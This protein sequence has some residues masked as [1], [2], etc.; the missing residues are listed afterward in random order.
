M[1]T[2]D[3]GFEWRV[4]DAGY[5]LDKRKPGDLRDGKSVR[6]GE[7]II[8][9]GGNMVPKKPMELRPQLFMDF[10]LLDGRIES[11]LGFANKWGYLG[12]GPTFNEEDWRNRDDQQ[13]FGGEDLIQWQNFIRLMHETVE[14][15][16]DNPSAL[17]KGGRNEFTVTEVDVLLIPSPPDGLPE[18]RTRP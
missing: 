5:Q 4:D 14:V 16:K 2:F 3:I 7:F 6:P 18:M 13:P 9:C 11:C 8:Q 15:W 17:F 1:T 10:A 12:V